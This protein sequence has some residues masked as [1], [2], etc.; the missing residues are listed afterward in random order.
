MDLASSESIGPNICWPRR[1]QRTFLSA[2]CMAG[3]AVPERL[4]H[5]RWQGTL[6]RPPLGLNYGCYVTQYRPSSIPEACAPSWNVSS[7]R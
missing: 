2:G 1:S 6:V 5:T 4:R 3:T 7:T